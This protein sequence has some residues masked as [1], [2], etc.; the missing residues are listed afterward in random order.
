MKLIKYFLA[1]TILSVSLF[2]FTAVSARAAES[3][4]VKGLSETVKEVPLYNAQYN[5]AP[6]AR[7]MLLNRVGG[8]VGLI[9]SFVGV[10]FLILTVYAGILWMTA[11]GN[12]A[13]VDKAKS[14]LINAVIGLIIISAAYSIT[15]FVGENI[16]K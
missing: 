8:V 10:L 3:Q 1:I 12:S 11:Q 4:T 7:T 14:L 15:I 5:E 9:L 6:S 2:S 16:A 13:Q